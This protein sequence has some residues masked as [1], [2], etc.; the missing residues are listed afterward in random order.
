MV[1]TPH[2][3]LT[4]IEQAQA[5][6]ELTANEAFLRLDALLN[7]SVLDKDLF[8]PPVS[9]ATGALYI[10]AATATGAWAGQEGNIAWYDQIWRF[11]TPHQGLTL[12]VA[13]EAALYTYNGVSWQRLLPA[14]SRHTQSFR[15]N[16]IAPAVSGGCAALATTA[17]AANQPDI[18]TL[19]FDAT[20]QEYAQFSLP[21]PKAWNA[22]TVSMQFLWSHGSASGSYGVMWSVQAL[23]F[24]D[25]DALTVNF[26]AA[27]SVTDTGGTANKLYASPE[28]AAVT[29]GNSPA[30]SDTVYVRI[31]RVATD[32]ADT[33]SVDARLHGV[34]LFYTATQYSDD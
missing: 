15:A 17:I 3:A 20:T 21:M 7:T 23:A 14:Q 12:W 6:K 27:V 34:R 8:T 13:D 24:G 29:I 4:L 28:T 31:S 16:A 26:P 2:L 32:A 11:I 18:Q 22:G 33:L 19:D 9:P 1:T 5:Q 30:Q 25:A 10:I